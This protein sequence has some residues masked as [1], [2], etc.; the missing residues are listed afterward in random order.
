MKT[1]LS[2][3]CTSGKNE[4]LK[5]NKVLTL[6]QE[7]RKG[8]YRS[9]SFLGSFASSNPGRTGSALKELLRMNARSLL[10]GNRP[11]GLRR[12]KISN[13]KLSTNL[14]CALRRAGSRGPGAILHPQGRTPESL[15]KSEAGLLH[16][17]RPKSSA[18]VGSLRRAGQ[19]RGN[20]APGVGQ[21]NRP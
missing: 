4:D 16:L 21:G 12:D 5:Q 2:F 11:R 14:H 17:L 9:W 15:R 10:R 1:Y 8:E 20:G 3:L 19:E 6:E 18:V 7:R 13:R